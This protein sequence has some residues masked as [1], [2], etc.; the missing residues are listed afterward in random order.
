MNAQARPAPARTPFWIAVGL[1][2]GR[3]MKVKMSSKAFVVTT[4]IMLGLLLAAVLVG[5]R[6]A[7]WLGGTAGADVAVTAETAQAV[8]ALGDS[9]DLRTVGSTDAAREAVRAGEVEAA[10]VPDE[11]G[12]AGLAVVGLDSA[13]TDLVQALSTTP[14]VELLDPNAAAPGL[15]Y[16]IAFGFGIVFFT[17]AITYGQQIAVSVIEEKQSRVVEILLAAIPAKAMMAGKVIGNS[18]M[19]LFQVALVAGVLLLGMQINETVLPLDGLG[20]PILWF[21][22]LFAIGFVMIASLYAAAASLVSRQEDIGSTSLPVMML[23]MLPYFAVIFFNDDPQALRIMSFIPFCAPVAVPLR[24]FLGQGETWEHVAALGVLVLS[25]GLAIWFAAT[26]Y[27]RSILRTG[28][29]MT[30][31]QA[32]RSRAV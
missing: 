20:A 15:Q 16:L 6:L 23:I 4:A 17:I 30:W 21:V 24:V 28:K 19:A 32:L 7:D 2:A 26:I 12:P 22:L 5:P 13:P 10:V 27:E 29:A 1:V 8:G 31:S 25:T 9:Y 3:E 11:A 14:A 18:A